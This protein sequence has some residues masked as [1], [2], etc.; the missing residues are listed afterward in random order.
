MSSWTMGTQALKHSL[1]RCSRGFMPRSPGVVA[2]DFLP[3][4]VVP[5]WKMGAGRLDCKALE[6]L[7]P[8][9][10]PSPSNLSLP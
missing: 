2:W 7:P 3:G 4:D 10:P 6:C 1:D 8:P 5:R 9:R